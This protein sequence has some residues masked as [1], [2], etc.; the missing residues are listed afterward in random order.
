VE[1]SDRRAVTPHPAGST[2]ALAFPEFIE[3]KWANYYTYLAGRS[4]AYPS[5]RLFPDEEATLPD[6]ATGLIRDIDGKFIQDRRPFFN[7]GRADFYLVRGSNNPNLEIVEPQVSGQALWE[8]GTVRLLKASE[9]KDL[10][11][12]GRGFYRLEYVSKES[13]PWWF[14][15]RFRWAAE[16]GEILHFNPAHPG[17]PT[18]S[19]SL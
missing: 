3:N 19:V 17:K 9:A 6:R 13:L 2:I 18:G 16:G 4:V 11:V 7:D 8:N 1:G 14:P 10:L 5:H 15:D 12:T